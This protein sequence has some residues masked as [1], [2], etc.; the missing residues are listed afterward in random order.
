MNGMSDFPDPGAPL[1]WDCLHS[2]M[3]Q[4]EFVPY[5]SQHPETNS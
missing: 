2:F 3:A 4:V 5:A 1:I